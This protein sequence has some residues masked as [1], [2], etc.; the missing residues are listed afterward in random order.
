MS[1]L[2]A[3]AQAPTL[4]TRDLTPIIGAEVQDLDVSKPLSDEVAQALREVW[5]EKGV[6]LL[7]GQ[8]LDEDEQVR[9][10]EV[11]GPLTRS[12]FIKPHHS[13]TNNA[14]MFVSNIREDGKLIGAHPDGEMH[15]HTDQCHQ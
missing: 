12:Q 3:D 2:M 15:F 6:L 7:R 10:A 11:F 1:S 13:K 5:H 14:V 4:K 9:F 8:S